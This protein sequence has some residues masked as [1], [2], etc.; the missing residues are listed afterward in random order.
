MHATC[1]TH[2]ILLDLICLIF[3]DEHRIWSFSLCNF[4]H[5]H[6][7]S[8]VFGPNII[9]RTLFPSPLSLCYYL[10]VRYQVSHPYKTTGRIVVLY[11]LA[12]TFLDSRREDKRLNR[13][14]ASIPWIYS[15]LLTSSCMTFSTTGLKG[16]L[17]INLRSTHL[18]LHLLNQ[19]SIE[20]SNVPYSKWRR[21]G[22]GLSK[23]VYNAYTGDKQITKS[24]SDYMRLMTSITRKFTWVA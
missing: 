5:S 11:I 23:S 4:L 10:G 22:A 6:V 18:N 1:P 3:G 24:E 15:L 8:S 12:F 21:F 2:L 16:D 14:V 9:I 7:T 17:K 20:N 19:E 13:M